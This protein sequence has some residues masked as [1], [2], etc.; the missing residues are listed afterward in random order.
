MTKW[1]LDNSRSIGH[2]PLVRLNRV[3]DGAGALVLAKIEGRNPAY[4]VKCRIGAAMIWDAEERGLLT[5]GKEIVEP[6]SGNTGIALAFVAAA[7]GIP[8]TLTMPETMSL[9]R[10]KLLLAYGAKL[11]LTEGAKG[12]KGAVAKA[13]EIAAS[14]PKYVLLQQFKN[15]AN[16]AIHQSTTGPEIWHD[17]DGK[18]DILVSG[19]GTGGTITGVSRY[20]KNTKGKKITSVA[21]EPSTSPVLTQKRNGEELKPSSHKIQG[22]GAGFVPDVLDLSLVDAIEQATNEEA[23]HFA[24]RLTREEGILSGISCGAAAAVAVRLAHR[25]E[26]AGKIIVTILPDSG[27]RYLSS[28]LFEGVFDA[29]GLPPATA[30]AA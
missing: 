3:T 11:V 8:L 17:T 22:I 4:S 9:E 20:I 30:K 7:R 18:I 13:E 24:R 5:A 2:T 28:V 21:V 25:P 16:P 26:N 23:I 14:D 27:E 12:M 29:T 10:R 15:P 6:T 1:F 19:V